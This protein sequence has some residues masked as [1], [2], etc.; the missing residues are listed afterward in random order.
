[1]F[2]NYFLTVQYIYHFSYSFPSRRPMQTSQKTISVI[3]SHLHPSTKH[4]VVS[5]C[6]PAPATSPEQK[7]ASALLPCHGFCSP[8]QEKLQCFLCKSAYRPM[9]RH[10]SSWYTGGTVL[11]S[12]LH[13]VIK[14]WLLHSRK[15]YVYLRYKM[16]L[17]ELLR[18]THSRE[19]IS[20]WG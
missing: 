3:C 7:E 16:A 12:L 6:S 15:D 17:H 13:H 2:K 1:M 8:F 14:P 18:K 9:K 10:C 19:S 20:R 11:N 5:N 4:C